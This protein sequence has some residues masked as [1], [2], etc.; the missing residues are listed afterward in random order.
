MKKLFYISFLFVCVVSFGQNNTINYRFLPSLA[1]VNLKPVSFQIN[2]NKN[3]FLSKKGNLSLYNPIT[4]LN[5]NYYVLGKSYR[6]SNT[7]TFSVYG[8]EGQRIDS[9]NP[10]GTKDLGSA[11]IF[12]A[13]TSILEIL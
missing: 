6:M 9:F 12:G 10:S 8:F 1:S 4:N 7:K 2:L 3:N 13:I 5:D 11:F